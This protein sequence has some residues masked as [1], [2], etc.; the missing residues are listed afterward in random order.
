[1]VGRKRDAVQLELPVSPGRGGRRAGAGR[2]PRD[3]Y[4]RASTLHR[5]REP[6]RRAHPVHVTLRTLPGLPRLR[7]DT[8]FDALVGAIRKSQRDDFRV[9]QFSVQHDHVHMLVE[10][11]NDDALSRGMSGLVIRAARALNRVFGRAGRLWG[12][13]WHGRALRAPRE[14]RTALAYLLFNARKHGEIPFGL[15]GYASTW[16][17][18]DYFADPVYREGLAHFAQQRTAPITPAQTWLLREGWKK[19]GLLSS[20][21]AAAIERRA[22][23]RRSA[24]RAHP[25]R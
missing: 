14:V 6:H 4:A 17:A 21:D 12:D 3:P 10:A 18:A 22:A 7:A 19:R 13:R 25:P 9:V 5:A 2:K 8:P 15:D 1:M 16:W 11:D 20:E 23:S 24:P